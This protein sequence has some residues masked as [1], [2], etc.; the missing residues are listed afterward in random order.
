MVSDG[1]TQIKP[2]KTWQRAALWTL[3]WVALAFPLARAQLANLA[4]TNSMPGQALMIDA[5]NARALASLASVIQI[6]G[7]QDQAIT[8]ARAALKREP[9]NVPALRTLGLAY[10]K[11]GNTAASDRILF[12]AGKLGWRDVA[13]QLALMKA[14]VMQGDADGAMQR[15]NALARTNHTPEVTYPIFLAALAEDQPR[16]ALVRAM[17]DR[18]TWRGNFFYNT[19][20]LP[21]EQ[22]PYLTKL[23]LELAQAGSPAVPSEKA[24]YLTRLVQVGAA[25]Q[26][27]AD[28]LRDQRAT[29]AVATTFPWD[30]GFEHVPATGTL[31]APF[32]W[33]VT[34]EST[35]VAAIVPAS[36]G[37]R[38]LSVST[39]RD[40]RGT[41]I[42]QT[43]ALPGGRYRLT[44]KIGGDAASDGLRWTLRCTPQNNEL[45]LDSV[46]GGSQFSSLSFD[47][48]AQS[49]AAQTLSLDMTSSGGGAGDNVTI[50]DVSIRKIG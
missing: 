32:E 49:C 48:P 18:P 41:L 35:G 5:G 25:R 14:Y 33:R 1:D 22:M 15:A 42:A 23:L 7:G 28:W 43:L 24:I 12:L 38:E 45:P 21:A 34:P 39:G 3:A 29:F 6:Q 50:D 37:G 47:I 26:A 13:L 31:S 8:L 9:M 30:G 2:R 4:V 27:Y 16:A 40:Y 10:A 36:G 11:M 44:T 20:Q 46:P 19:L 17:A